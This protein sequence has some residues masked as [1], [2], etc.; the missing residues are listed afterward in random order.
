MQPIVS[1]LQ[2]FRTVAASFLEWWWGE[3]TQIAALYFPYLKTELPTVMLWLSENSVEIWTRRGSQ[4]KVL[5][6]ALPASFLS[7]D[8]LQL[9]RLRSVAENSRIEIC[10]S[11]KDICLLRLGHVGRMAP[12]QESVKYQLLQESPID[13]G[14]IAFAWRVA[15]IEEKREAGR[16]VLDVAI[17]R[18]EDLDA[19]ARA[20]ENYGLLPAT[21]GYA[22]PEADRLTFVLPLRRE[23]RRTFSPK[24]HLNEILVASF[25]FIPVLAML[26]VGMIATIQA[27]A[28]RDEFAARNAVLKKSEAL[29]RRQAEL[30]AVHNEL[31]TAA[32]VP[33]VANLMDDL[34]RL[35]PTDTWVSEVRLEGETLRLSGFSADPASA[36][37]AICAS[38]R[39]T[40]IRLGSVTAP[41]SSR[42]ISQIE[43]TASLVPKP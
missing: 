24:L 12:T 43:I 25:A 29:M 27:R 38:K 13:A 5:E 34:G 28:T 17:C 37:K 35:V 16:T 32:L 10:L 4:A 1:R 23:M 39:M 9:G 6:F 7:L 19:V 22:S 11:D 2:T 20:A 33:S 40:N 14:R 3:L 18:Q 30:L 8:P 36:A 15:A 21:I 42:A 31:R 41:A 26:L